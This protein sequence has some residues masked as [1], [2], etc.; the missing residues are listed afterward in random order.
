MYM[1]PVCNNEDFN[2]HGCEDS[3][4]AVCT[5]CGEEFF[6]DDDGEDDYDD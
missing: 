6:D 4:V 2:Y 1:C 3:R 5:T